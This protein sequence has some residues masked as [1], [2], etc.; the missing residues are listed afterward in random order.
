MFLDIRSYITLSILFLGLCKAS[1]ISIDQLN[2]EHSEATVRQVKAAEIRKYFNSSADPCEDFFEFT[3]GNYDVYYP[4]NTTTN[5]FDTLQQ[6]MYNK[7]KKEMEIDDGK[8]T[9]V[10]RKVKD[11]Y[12]SCISTPALLK[13]YK[14]K[15]KE[16]IREFGKMPVLE[17]REWQEENFEWSS[18]LSKM[19]YKTGPKIMFDIGVSS[20]LN[21]NTVNR[22]S[23]AEPFFNLDDISLYVDEALPTQREKFKNEMAKHLN[24]F[25][26]VE[27]ELANRTAQEMLDFEAS[28]AR[29]MFDE[30]LDMALDEIYTLKSMDEV[31]EKYLAAWDTKKLINESLGFVPNEIIIQPAYL[32]HTFEVMRN[33]SPRVVANFIFYQYLSRFI[34]EV[35]DNSTEIEKSCIS[36]TKQLLYKPLVNLIYRKYFSEQMKEGVRFMWQELKLAFQNALSNSPRL[37]WM[38]EEARQYAVEKLNA[39]Q[40]QILSYENMNFSEYQDL[41]LNNHDWIHNLN[42]LRAFKAKTVRDTF[43]G[44]PEPLIATGFSPFNVVIENTVKIPLDVLQPFYAW[45]NSYPYA[46]NFGTLGFFVAHEIVHGFDDTGRT[47]DTKGNLKDWWDPDSEKEFIEHSKCFVEQYKAYS[48]GG[49]QLPERQ[50]QGENIA[51]N[52]GVRLAYEAYLNWYAK[53]EE[54]NT[55]ETFPDLDYNN[56]QL[57]FISYAQVWCASTHPDYMTTQAVSDIHVPEKFRV[58][59]PLSNFEEFSKEFNCPLGSVMNPV[60]KCGIY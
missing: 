14:E 47:C 49:R 37:Q 20:D 4:T 60:K 50:A 52:G 23:M 24:I 13:E 58:I 31:Q 12:R 21:D 48:Y 30:G 18:T 8:D 34:Y 25:L 53:Q 59:G 38:S 17:G 35:T 41:Q 10:D 33:A 44:P 28:L 27:E 55:T 26:D 29:G 51:D 3:C 32:D 11:F 36:N 15:L 19:I 1:P 54:S 9:D 22:V 40:L 16:L 6:A 45:S 42:V 43:H 39:M 56:R 57:F 46:Y 2:L 5:T 7:I